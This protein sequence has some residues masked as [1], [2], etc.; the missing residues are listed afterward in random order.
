MEAQTPTHRP[1]SALHHAGLAVAVLLV[2]ALGL[3]NLGRPSFWHDELVHVYVAKSMAGNG[4]PT[5]PSG[6]FYPNG[7]TYHA[8]LV[9]PSLLFGQDEA[10]MR[11]PSVLV[12]ACAVALAFFFVRRMA[13]PGAA[14][15]CALVLALCPWTV[16]W[17]REARFYTL[18]P[19]L[20]VAWL[21]L[22]WHT[23]HA[24]GRRYAVLAA[25]GALAV[26]VAAMFTSFQLILFLG[27]VGVLTA[28]VWW[29]EPVLRMRCV[30]L[31][32]ALTVLGVLTILALWFNPNPIDRAAVFQT[33]L[34]GDLVDPQRMIRGYYL[35]WLAWNLS[36]TYLA[37]ALLGFALL[38][39]KGR[40]EGLYITLAFWVPLLILTFLVGYRRPRFMFFIFPLYAAA[41]GYTMAHIPGWMAGF[42]KGWFGFVRALF[43]LVLAAALARSGMLLTRDSVEVAKGA[44]TTLARKHPQWRAPG[45]W[46]RDHATPGDAILTTTFLPAYHYVG[47]VDNWFPNRFTAWE[48]QES[49][50][51]GL[52]DLAAL[53]QWLEEHPRGYYLA[54][55]A[56]FGLYRHDERLTSLRE[57]FDWVNDHME[58]V[59]A[60]CN[61][62]VAVYRWDFSEVTKAP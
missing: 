12:W 30:I 34:G 22:A 2:L 48:V 24:K 11:A 23:V 25:L 29:R 45:Q 56:L 33:G 51:E 37:A 9:I 46:V 35:R 1:S 8:L 62:D 52:P 6:A 36:R 3:P 60:A 7:T 27:P 59:E 16:A 57:E 20:Y 41:I 13:G 19:L 17:S 43:A 26:F 5:L 54:D 15:A 40:R 28:W 44:D 50:L 61:A 4:W 42:R 39:W 10:P 31:F 21:W 18:Q 38:L 47:R 49:G 14:V 58:R 53:L 32:A 55:Y